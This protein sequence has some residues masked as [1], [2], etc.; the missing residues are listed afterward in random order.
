M[1]PTR[2][3][4]PVSW[5]QRSLDCDRK[6]NPSQGKRPAGSAGRLQEGMSELL[7][8]GAVQCALRCPTATLD[9]E[10]ARIRKVASARLLGLEG[11]GCGQ[12][13]LGHRGSRKQQGDGADR[14]VPQLV[15]ADGLE[16]ALDR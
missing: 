3:R 10:T 1:D 2:R 11:S 16:A 13:G 5:T 7:R 4:M 8:W 9:T 6:P 15:E 12:D 14:K